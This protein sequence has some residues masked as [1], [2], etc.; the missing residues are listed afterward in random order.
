MEKERILV[1]DNK[2]IFLKMFKRKFKEEF[3]F[4][5]NS[6]VAKEQNEIKNFDHFVYVVYDK[7]E[8]VEFLKLEN[9]GTNVL[10][11]LFDKQLYEKLF[12]LEEVNDLSLLDASKTR[13][14]IINDLKLHFAR[15]PNSASKKETIK[16]SSSN[17]LQ[18]QFNNYYKTLFFLM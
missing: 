18:T 6:S 5:E 11:C 4:F 8:L 10:V 14:E 17:I 13:K 2:N 7:L 15:I 9:K 3:D 16:F 12:F 1:H